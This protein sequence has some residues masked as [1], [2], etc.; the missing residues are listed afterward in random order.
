MYIKP[1]MTDSTALLALALQQAH[2]ASSYADCKQAW[3]AWVGNDGALTKGKLAAYKT[4]DRDEVAQWEGAI[5]TVKLR[6]EARF[7]EFE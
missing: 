1:K 7:E 5:S 6:L 3:Q 2:A 4:G